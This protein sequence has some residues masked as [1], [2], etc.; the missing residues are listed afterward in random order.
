MLGTF[1][2]KLFSNIKDYITVSMVVLNCCKGDKPSQWE[3]PIFG[4][5]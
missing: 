5:L 3:Y 4:P 2:L 1:S